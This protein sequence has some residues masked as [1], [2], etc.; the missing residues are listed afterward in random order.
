[1]TGSLILTRLGFRCWFRV[2][3]VDI[4]S[5]QFASLWIKIRNLIPELKTLRAGVEKYYD[6]DRNDKRQLNFG[7]DLQVALEKIGAI[8]CCYGGGSLSIL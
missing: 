2:E 5:F 1:M 6:V 3:A 7:V 8:L 4:R